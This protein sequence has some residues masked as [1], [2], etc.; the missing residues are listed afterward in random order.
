M[1][2]QSHVDTRQPVLNLKATIRYS[3]GAARKA[4]DRDFCAT[5]WE[6]RYQERGGQSGRALGA[7]LPTTVVT[8][9]LSAKPKSE[10]FAGD[11]HDG[12]WLGRVS[13]G[14]CLGDIP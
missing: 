13:S 7:L 4:P 5:G 2:H 6:V 1:P 14:A 12:F 10:S 9:G 11:F 3:S 8:S